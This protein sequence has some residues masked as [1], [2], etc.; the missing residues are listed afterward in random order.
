MYLIIID[1]R[2]PELF[3]IVRSTFDERVIWDRR[4]RERRDGQRRTGRL[5]ATTA[6]RRR[7]ERRLGSPQT[8][9]AYGFVLTELDDTVTSSRPPGQ[10]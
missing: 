5:A 6:G 1:R 3:D 7:N 4:T 10:A 8:W 2:R 9:T